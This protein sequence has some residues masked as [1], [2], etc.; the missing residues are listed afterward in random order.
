MRNEGAHP[1]E[2]GHTPSLGGGYGR[3]RADRASRSRGP[4]P[5]DIMKQDAKCRA[6]HQPGCGVRR[7]LERFCLSGES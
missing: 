1:T 5:G 7:L 4:Q 2:G 6:G 3:K